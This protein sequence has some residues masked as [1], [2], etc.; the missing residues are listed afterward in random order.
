MEREGSHILVT[1]ERGS[2]QGSLGY[3]LMRIAGKVVSG[4]RGVVKSFK[5]FFSPPSKSG[6]ANV[7]FPRP[8]F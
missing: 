6:P 1:P 5:D 2:G 4:V 3:S 7:V 8:W